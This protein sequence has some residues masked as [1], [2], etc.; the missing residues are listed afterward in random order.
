MKNSRFLILLLI[1]FTSLLSAEAAA[2]VSSK[3]LRE[4]A[5]EY[6]G[7]TIVFQGE[8]IGDIMLRGE[9]AWINVKD[10]S[11]AVGVFC[12]KELTDEIEYL[13]GYKSSGDLISVRGEFHEQ[14]PQHGGDTDIHAEKITIIKSGKEISRSLEPQKVKA[15]IFLPA[16]VFVLAII[17]LIVR[18][19]R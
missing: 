14:C 2:G 1:F 9:F 4:S 5:Q 13:G 8:A 3:D 16:I 7:K 19:F 18:R 11:G 17:H 10:E 15:S 6:D 12:P